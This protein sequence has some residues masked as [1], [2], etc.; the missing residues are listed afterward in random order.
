[1]NDLNRNPLSSNTPDSN[2]HVMNKD[3]QG[4]CRIQLLAM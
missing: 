3:I 2:L 1:M 4:L